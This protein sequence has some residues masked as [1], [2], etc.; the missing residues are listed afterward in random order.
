VSVA[1]PFELAAELRRLDESLLVPSASDGGID[2]LLRRREEVVRALRESCAPMRLES[3]DGEAR[4][5][6]ASLLRDSTAQD[7]RLRASLESRRERAL[8]DLASNSRPHSIP[9]APEPRFTE[10]VA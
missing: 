7:A 5:R 1:C 3:M 6:L 2:A 8:A 4:R 9:L 10:R